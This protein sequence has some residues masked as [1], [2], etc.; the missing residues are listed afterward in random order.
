M[1]TDKKF[2]GRKTNPTHSPSYENVYKKIYPTESTSSNEVDP[3]EQY[4]INDDDVRKNF[5]DKLYQSIPINNTQNKNQTPSMS[6]NNENSAYKN[7]LDKN[8]LENSNSKNNDNKNSFENDNFTNNNTSKILENYNS[9][10]DNLIN[11]NTLNIYE[12]HNLENKID[13][14][15]INL[16]IIERDAGNNDANC[17]DEDLN[18]N[19]SNVNIVLP[20]NKH[21]NI[22]IIS[23]NNEQTLKI[24]N[25]DD[26]IDVK[27]TNNQKEKQT[28]KNNNLKQHKYVGV[29]KKTASKPKSYNSEYDENSNFAVNQENND[30]DIQTS[31]STYS[32]EDSQKIRKE[33]KKKKCKYCQRIES[34]F[35]D[36]NQFF[37]KS[38][39]NELHEDNNTYNKTENIKNKNTIIY[40]QNIKRTKTT[41]TEQEIENLKEGLKKYENDVN[42]YARILQEYDFNGRTKTD[43]KDKHRNM[44]KKTS[45]HNLKP[46]EFVYVDSRG[47]RIPDKHGKMLSFYNR[48][49]YDAAIRIANKYMIKENTIIT[50]SDVN[51]KNY[52][53][54]Y[55]VLR[56]E[57]NRLKVIAKTAYYFE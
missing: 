57:N 25:I 27:N 21:F 10:N 32:N 35:E 23:N 42:K 28:I 40:N 4:K 47:N 34:E 26:S 3:L 50:L 30:Y 39:I 24:S 19:S 46:R 1:V 33:N 8:I 55:L 45:Y 31:N 9:V 36:K 13:K 51:Q 54:D 41:W 22:N 44:I 6:K 38:S 2:L 43:L 49:P 20:D 37:D 52:L 53:R 11:N 17:L 18:G 15:E 5:F 16:Q 12:N 56:T 7:S 29:A 14:H 48:Y